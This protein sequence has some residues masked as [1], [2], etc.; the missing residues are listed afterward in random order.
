MFDRERGVHYYRRHV[1]IGPA[2][3]TT[4]QF[5][6]TDLV[7]RLAAATVAA[8]DQLHSLHQSPSHRQT[9]SETGFSVT[10]AVWRDKKHYRQ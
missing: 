8:S 9:L 2:A 6:G 3:A 5:I 10:A 7:V 4:P 1:Y